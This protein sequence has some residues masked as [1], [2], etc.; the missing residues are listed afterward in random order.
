MSLN[1]PNARFCINRK[2]APSLTLP[3]FFKLVS[4]LGIH[5]VELRNDMPS[6]RVTDDLTGDEVKALARESGIRI[7]TINALYP[8]IS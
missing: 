4:Q 1:I 7:V 6:G 3:Q 2:I 8:L 5:N